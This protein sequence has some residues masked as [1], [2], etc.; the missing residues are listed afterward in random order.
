MFVGWGVLQIIR[1][2]RQQQTNAKQLSELVTALRRDLETNRQ[3]VARLTSSIASTAVAPIAKSAPEAKAEESSL[4]IP[5]VEQEVEQ[6]AISLPPPPPRERYHEP[7]R[8]LH[9]EPRPSYAE[10]VAAKVER[11]HDVAA[12]VQHTPREPNRYEVA[13]KEA[14]EKIWN[15]IIVGQDHRPE[16]VSLEYAVASN[17]LLRIG[18]VILVMGVGFFLKYSVQ[19]QLISEM[20]QV[21]LTIVAGAAMLA[22]G[23]RML[24][25]QYQLLGQG[26][27][28]GGIAVLY[29]A[30]FAAA[31]R[32]HLIGLMPAFALMALITATAGILAVTYR[33]LLVAVLGI[34]GGYA[35][36]LMLASGE[37]N[38][39]GLFTYIL[40]LGIGV[41]GISFKRDWRLLVWLGFMGNYTLFFLA[42]EE[43]HRANFW[44]VLPF[45]AAFFVLYSTAVFIFN[46][47][48]RVKSTLLELLGLWA[49]AGVFFA[50]SY[51][52]VRDAY[53]KYA[54]AGVTLA[55][56]AF[57]IA[58]VFVLLKQ[59]VHDR[60]LMLSFTAL[61]AV[62]LSVTLPLVL[63]R[64]WITAS[65]AVQ[66]V[67]ML[68]VAGKLNSRFVRILAY[69]LYVIVVSR[70][71]FVDLPNQYLVG[72]AGATDPF[73]D[74][75]MAMF[76]RVMM[77]G[78]PVASLALGC[79]LVQHPPGAAQLS[80][81]SADDIGAWIE[82]RW[83]LVV[84]G[85]L[86]LGTLFLALHLELNRSVGYFFEPARLPML[87]L[88]WAALCAVL[89]QVY[90]RF[91]TQSLLTIL[92]LFVAGTVAKLFFFDL[93]YWNVDQHFVYGGSYSFLAATMRLLDFAFVAAFLGYAFVRLQGNL[94][95][96]QARLGLGA[97]ALGLSFVWSTLELHTLLRHFMPGMESGGVSI[98]WSLYALGLI[99]SGIRQRVRP[100][101]FVGLALFGIVVWKVFFVDLA[102]LDQLY[103][104]IAFLVLGVLVL[105]GSFVY[106]KYRPTF[107]SDTIPDGKD[108]S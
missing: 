23:T 50:T 64:Q 56:A 51:V 90:L 62:F 99:L 78:I 67:V 40:V 10:S 85:T 83:A 32:F 61:S 26:L 19:N 11:L 95:A 34:I 101:R 55:M 48:N 22:A 12:T 84:G 9:P 14:L 29:L 108:A 103:R 87:T 30:V 15:W 89:L 49:N 53:G 47:M 13:A 27:M 54:E 20:G 98:L 102:Q 4:P 24:G 57:F 21:S 100:L 39:V 60:E 65:W 43:Y 70:F 16:G 37:P 2:Q 96:E 28:G 76:E 86:M 17:W 79:R 71:A 77:F 59:K 72:Q 68:W 33:S 92:L 58:H 97:T 82:D 73:W 25:K 1:G 44:E 93:P 69:L 88:L 8:V 81:D 3:A 42:M 52:L 107:A 66:A 63:S 36:P 105:C 38:F 80:V 91:R 7:E 5:T 75:V 106:L 45:L 18:I 31:N 94:T 41:L 74:Y 35:T 104:I 6:P 46:V